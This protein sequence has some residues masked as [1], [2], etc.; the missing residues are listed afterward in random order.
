M[1]RRHPC[2]GTHERKLSRIIQCLLIVLPY[3]LLDHQG[4]VSGFGIEGGRMSYGKMHGSDWLPTLVSSSTLDCLSMHVFVRACS[5]AD[6]SHAFAA[7]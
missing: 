2:C 1:G 4:L 6:T 7:R 5:S 3:H